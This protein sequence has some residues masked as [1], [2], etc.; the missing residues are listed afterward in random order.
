MH[1]VFVPSDYDHFLSWP[2]AMDKWL[3]DINLVRSNRMY[4]Y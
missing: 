1:I 3:L 2:N 4:I